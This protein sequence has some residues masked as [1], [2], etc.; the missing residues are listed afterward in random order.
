MHNINIVHYTRIEISYGG[1][2]LITLTLFYKNNGEGTLRAQ[3]NQL[4]DWHVKEFDSLVSV[5][6]L[7][8]ATRRHCSEVMEL[9]ALPSTNPIISTPI[10][11][12]ERIA[13]STFTKPPTTET[14]LT[15]LA[16]TSNP[17][18][19]PII[20]TGLTVT[21]PDIQQ[22]IQPPTS[23]PSSPAANI[24]RLSST[25]APH[26]PLLIT[27]TS[28]VI[29]MVNTLPASQSADEQLTSPLSDLASSNHVAIPQSPVQETPIIPSAITSPESRESQS[30]ITSPEHKEDLCNVTSPEPIVDT[31][32][33]TETS[34]LTSLLTQAGGNSE[35]AGGELL[36]QV[37][38]YL[39]SLQVETKTQINNG[40]KPRLSEIEQKIEELNN[41]VTQLEKENKSLRTQVSEMKKTCK[42]LKETTSRPVTSHDITTQTLH[43]TPAT[44][45]QSHQNSI[46]DSPKGPK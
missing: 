1:R 15:P 45:P 19:S 16:S 5:I 22:V 28:P 32:G 39:K 40:L 26:S 11:R 31:S 17:K 42:A 43:K 14:R 7:V 38:S 41:K 3:G 34:N 4:H 8:G 30:Q 36:Q 18:T 9:T 20:E 23:P 12:S 27:S 33:V 46:N 37:M 25:Q 2:R 24:I 6:R 10:R 13:K 29:V 21:S 35:E 44:S